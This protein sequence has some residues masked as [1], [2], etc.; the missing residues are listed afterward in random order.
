MVDLD[1]AVIRTFS[2]QTR[3]LDEDEFELHRVELDY[4]AP[5]V[6]L[7]RE[8]AAQ[9]MDRVSLGA[10]SRRLSGRCPGVRLAHRQPRVHR[11][12]PV[13][14]LAAYKAISTKNGLS[15]MVVLYQAGRN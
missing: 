1:L 4:P 11:A 8:T 9:L 10:A 15:V 13:R 6:D 7:A 3:L 2:G 12:L 14:A 5:M